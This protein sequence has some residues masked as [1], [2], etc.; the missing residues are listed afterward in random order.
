MESLSCVADERVWARVVLIVEAKAPWRLITL[1]LKAH[2]CVK[3]NTDRHVPLQW[4]GVVVEPPVSK[5]VDLVLWRI[6][7]E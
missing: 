6:L 5:V 3:L 7:V 4:L 1:F 2:S